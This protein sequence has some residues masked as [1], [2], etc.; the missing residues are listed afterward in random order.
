MRPIV[1]GALSMPM[2]RFQSNLVHSRNQR[3]ITK[4]AQGINKNPDPSGLCHSVP[5]AQG[6]LGL[7]SHL[8][9]QAKGSRASGEPKLARQFSAT[10]GAFLLPY[11][12][13]SLLGDKYF[14]LPSLSI[15]FLALSNLKRIMKIL[16]T[17]IFL[18]DVLKHQL[19]LYGKGSLFLALF[20]VLSTN[21]WKNKG[22]IKQ[23]YIF[24]SF[25]LRVYTLTFL[26]QTSCGI[27]N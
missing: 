26:L 25:F 16:K 20:M 5:K 8:V 27:E 22:E 12:C 10:E 18:K 11:L 6:I 3:I 24:P 21:F 9:S 4:E 23:K 17:D 19:F 15:Y 13:P 2:R 7:S 14:S 1:C